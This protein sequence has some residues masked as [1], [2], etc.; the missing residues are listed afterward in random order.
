MF[1]TGANVSGASSWALFAISIAANVA[2]IVS[3][4]QW[5]RRVHMSMI[6]IGWLAAACGLF[7]LCGCLAIMTGLFQP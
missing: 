1:L 7:S 3:L 5:R 6:I 2:I 4:L